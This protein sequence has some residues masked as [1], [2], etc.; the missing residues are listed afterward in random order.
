[1]KAIKTEWKLAFL[2]TWIGG[3]LAHA[4]RFF[5][6]LP[7]ADTMRGLYGPGATYRSGRW[8]LEWTSKLSTNYELTWVNA[9]LSLLYISIAVIMIVELLKMKNKYSIIL[10]ALLIVTFPTITSTFA[11]MF[12]ADSYMMAF[13]M[14]V[15]GI[16]FTDQYKFGFIPGM[17]CV[18]LSMSTYQAYLSV[19]L[20]LVLI[21]CIKSVLLDDKNFLQTLQ[22][23]YKQLVTLVGGAIGNKLLT[24]IINSYVGVT[25]SS[26]QGINDVHLLTIEDSIK[27]VGTS[28][29]SF[30]LFFMIG[31]YA[32]RS[33]YS[34]L[35]QLVLLTVIGFSI[36]F[37]F[38]KKVYK[39]PIALCCIVI[40]YLCYPML[41]YIIRFVSVKVEYHT[42]MVMSLCLIYVFLLLLTEYFSGVNIF[43][44]ILQITTTIILCGVCYV[45]ILNANYSYYQM[46]LS[47]EK[48][49]AIALDILSRVEEIEEFDGTQEIAICGSYDA[50]TYT[51][52]PV[53]PEMAG[54]SNDTVFAS[55]QH[56]L[57]M[58][59]YCMGRMYIGAESEKIEKL[60]QTSEWSKMNSYPYA[61]CVELIDDVVVIKLS[62]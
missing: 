17:I 1:M 29:N 10:T 34:R 48:S 35:N 61:G 44:R 37:A 18:C 13:M 47:Y 22:A 45:N 14:A 25:L 56:Y 42:L 5:N 8:F 11:Y 62:E 38:K 59:K 53:I 3:L 39:R 20:V 36:Y 21:I 15:A 12:T 26:Y 2:A 43:E 52:D 4:Y 60:C 16:Y 24:T 19:S 31:D 7:T 51:M 57:T 6:F 46:N 32:D 55:Q 54:V 33:I 41:S 23:R 30:K 40:A 28:W 50:T 27:A 49:Y 58:W 9:T